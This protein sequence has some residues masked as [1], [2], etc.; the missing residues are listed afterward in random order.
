MHKTHLIALAALLTFSSLSPASHA[1]TVPTPNQPCATAGDFGIANGKMMTC[2]SQGGDLRW[3][4]NTNVIAG[5]LCS[6]W[7]PGD[8]TVWAELQ[9]LIKGTW[10][11]QA[12]P[13]AFTPGP[14]CDNTKLNSSIPWIALPK[15]IADGTKYRWVKGAIGKDGH[16]G[17]QYAKG[18]PEPAFTYTAAAM[19]AKYLKRYTAIESPIYGPHAYA[20][21]IA[22]NGLSTPNASSTTEET[23]SPT[24]S[25]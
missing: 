1:F 23:P 22:A 2:V 17:P 13:I 25:S 4:L 20:A 9:L 14:P 15:K 11:T 7:T 19:K 21:F 10:Q 12:L 24:P 5:G 16:G 3:Q 6:S 18:Y 8:K